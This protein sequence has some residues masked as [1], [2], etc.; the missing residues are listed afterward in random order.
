MT[1]SESKEEAGFRET[2][3]PGPGFGSGAKAVET[4]NRIWIRFF[5][6]FA[7]GW[8]PLRRKAP[9]IWPHVSIPYSEPEPGGPT[10][11]PLRTSEFDVAG[12]AM[13]D[14]GNSHP[15]SEFRQNPGGFLEYLKRTHR[16]A[17]LTV[18][19]RAE[20]VVQ[21]VEGYRRLLDLAANAAT[22]VGIQRGLQG[23][24]AGTG[25]DVE[26]AFASLA[27]ELGVSEQG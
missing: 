1:I 24:H 6:G 10:P 7:S 22:V 12:D 18:H 15:L 11:S 16:P 26:D 4:K 17:V 8:P 9:C 23:M 19:G 14:L 20:L 27:R 3:R 5:V 21:H 25:E 13:I 2:R